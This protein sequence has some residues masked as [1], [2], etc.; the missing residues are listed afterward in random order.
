MLYSFSPHVGSSQ[1]NEQFMMVLRYRV[2]EESMMDEAILRPLGGKDFLRGFRS[3]WT[4]NATPKRWKT[5][6]V[7][8][9]FL[10]AENVVKSPAQYKFD[11]V[12]CITFL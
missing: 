9:N 2:Y 6:F 12:T 1:L 4:E 10:W 5:F 7:L 8:T 3:I 11:P